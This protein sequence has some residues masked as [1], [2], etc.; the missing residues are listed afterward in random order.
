MREQRRGEE[1]RVQDIGRDENTA[2]HGRN[3]RKSQ[4]KGKRREENR[5]RK[6]SWKK[7]HRTSKREHNLTFR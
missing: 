1:V 2:R 3:E 6:G 4:M 7:R 5:G